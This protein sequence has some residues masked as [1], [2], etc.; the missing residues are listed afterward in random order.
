MKKLFNVAYLG[1][2]YYLIYCC[3]DRLYMKAEKKGYNEGIQA[4]RAIG[5]LEGY[6]D[7]MNVVKNEDHEEPKNEEEGLN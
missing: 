5:K 3:I 6:L 1:S 4:G 7:S 2:M